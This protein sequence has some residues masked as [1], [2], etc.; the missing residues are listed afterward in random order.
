M[1]AGDIRPNARGGRAARRANLRERE[2]DR[3]ETLGVIKNRPTRGD[4]ARAEARN[5]PICRQA[6]HP[7]NWS[8]H[9]TI[10]H[11]DQAVPLHEAEPGWMPIVAIRID[12]GTQPRAQTEEDVIN[13]YAD[14]MKEGV[15]F[16]QVIVFYD[17]AAYWLADGFHRVEAA[18]RVGHT[19]I[20]ADV[21]QGTQRDA[22]LFSAGAN[23][24]H[25]LRRTNA[26]K[27]RAV[28]RLLLDAEWGKWSN[29]Q[30]A[31]SCSVSHQFVNNLRSSLATDASEIRTYTTKHGTPA[32]MNTGNIGKFTPPI[33]Y[34]QSEDDYQP[35]VPEVQVDQAEPAKTWEEARLEPNDNGRYSENETEWRL[36]GRG[37][38]V[39]A[40]SGQTGELAF[41]TGRIAYVDTANGRKQY[42]ALYLRKVDESDISQ[43]DEPE[44]D[45]SKT[46]YP[47]TPSDDEQVERA[48]QIALRLIGDTKLQLE[49]RIKGNQGGSG[50]LYSYNF[51]GGQVYL[52]YF[53][54]NKSVH[55]FARNQIALCIGDPGEERLF[56][57]NAFKLLEWKLAN[58][59]TVQVDPPTTD[60]TEEISAPAATPSG[61]VKYVCVII[62]DDISQ[63]DAVL[64]NKRTNCE[65]FMVSAADV[66]EIK[67]LA[68]HD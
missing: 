16:P 28:N 68:A 13:E 9:M 18:K 17:G 52:N 56:R 66:E 31:K 4:V 42:D 54:P 7:T 43:D 24:S 62:T 60:E 57:F 47:V 58:Q 10:K 63:F 45:E 46:L 48:R 11:P 36:G 6:V 44:A 41:V 39:Q 29:N 40:R 23:A 55:N 65:L 64:A 49:D 30:I 12:G 26:D 19:D 15:Q 8:D 61:I 2:Q 20:P 51:G 21:R 25:G 35:D 33:R 32:Q 1:T 27:R 50:G 37:A 38:T 53:K 3:L 5:C 67:R 34:G 59:P 14:A 22:I